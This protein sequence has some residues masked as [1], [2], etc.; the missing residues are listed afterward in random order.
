MLGRLRMSPTECLESYGDLAERVFGRPRFIH[1]L[2]FPFINPRCKFNHVPL[3]EAIKDITAKFDHS[4]NPDASFRQ[5][6]EKV[7]RT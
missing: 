4:R 7:C 2:R 3:E 5:P 6:C 1:A